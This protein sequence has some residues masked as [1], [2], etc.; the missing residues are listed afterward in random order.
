MPPL[1]PE[2]MREFLDWSW[3]VVV[4][5]LCALWILRRV[6]TSHRGDLCSQSVAVVCTGLL[7]FPI[8][9]SDDDL[10]AF[11]SCQLLIDAEDGSF[12][13]TKKAPDP[14][15]PSSATDAKSLASMPMRIVACA[16]A[17][18]SVHPLPN[19]TC[20]LQPLHHSFGRRAPP[21]GV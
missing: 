17:G 14:G 19:P 9:S 10:L 15:R 5:W 8:I 21:L 7:L 1:E 2:L 13:S 11:H 18:T 6:A 12:V 4:V 3:V 20:F 16:G